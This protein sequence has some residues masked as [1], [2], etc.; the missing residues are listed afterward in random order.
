[1]PRATRKQYRAAS[2]EAAHP[3]NIGQ[4][5]ESIQAVAEARRSLVWAVV[6]AQRLRHVRRDVR[7]CLRSLQRSQRA[8]YQLRVAG[9]RHAGGARGGGD[10]GD[11]EGAAE[12]PVRACDACVRA[13]A[14]HVQEAEAADAR[15]RDLV[16]LSFVAVAW[17][18]QIIWPETS[19][20]EKYTQTHPRAGSTHAQATA[21]HRSH[22]AP[23][24]SAAQGHAVQAHTALLG[25]DRA[26]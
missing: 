6:H 10:A 12:P 24:H 15:E 13:P 19:T 9:G 8:L 17:P 25:A 11:A 4:K 18:A 1:M 7:P 20:G 26:M 14:V 2:P 21:C 3:R 22:R 23:R 5:D 16:P